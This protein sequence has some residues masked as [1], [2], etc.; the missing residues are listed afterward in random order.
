[1]QRGKA[2]CDGLTDD[3]TSRATEHPCYGCPDRTGIRCQ[4]FGRSVTQGAC[5][6]V[7]WRGTERALEIVAEEKARRATLARGEG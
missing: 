5:D 6:N 3:G 4:A 7:F 1:M 2:R